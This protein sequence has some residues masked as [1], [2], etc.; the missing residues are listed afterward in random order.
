LP[1]TSLDA[2]EPRPVP[3]L[4]RVDCVELVAVLLRPIRI[5]SGVLPVTDAGDVLR[6]SERGVMAGGVSVRDRVVLE[7]FPLLTDGLEIDGAAVRELFASLFPRFVFASTLVLSIRVRVDPALTSR[8]LLP[9]FV[10]VADC[11]RVLDEVP[12]LPRD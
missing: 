12:S 5:L 10:D 1:G 7:A 2:E 3:A 9:V 6:V 8:T 4:D 11:W